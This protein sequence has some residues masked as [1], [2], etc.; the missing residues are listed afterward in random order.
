M[1]KVVPR[2]YMGR[3]NATFNPI[4]SASSMIG[5]FGGGLLYS[6]VMRNFDVTIGGI[7]FGPIDT[8]FLGAGALMLVASA[9]ALRLR[10]AGEL[11]P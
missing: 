6:T 5:I 7:H 4:I 11:K 10:Y 9:Y 3:I 2:A 1:F 8:I